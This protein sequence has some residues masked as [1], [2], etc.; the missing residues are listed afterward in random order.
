MDGV[1]WE[2]RERRQPG[3]SRIPAQLR[4]EILEKPPYEVITINVSHNGMLLRASHKREID[5]FV[6]MRL[7]LPPTQEPVEILGRVASKVHVGTKEALGIHFI[8]FPSEEK[9]KW[10][11]YLK[12]IEALA[13]DASDGP[14]AGGAPERRSTRRIASAFMVRFKSG[15]GLEEFVTQNI[16]SGGMFLAT[17]RTKAEGERIRLVV[18]HPVTDRTFELEA[19]VAR[20][21]GGSAPIGLMGVALRFLEM[22]PE[23]EAE[24]KLFVGP[25]AEEPKEVPPEIT[26]E[27]PL[28]PPPD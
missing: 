14:R 10:L 17:T 26:Q 3:P 11:A 9:E 8:D 4:V 23:K 7:F 16:S 12:R 20:S 19:E 1:S 5:S 2:K 27:S 6:R 24:F 25:A 21:E 22:T 15:E 28:D 13:S 18:I